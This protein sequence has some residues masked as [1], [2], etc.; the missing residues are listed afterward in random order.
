MATI[1]KRKFHYY[2]PN[3]K[4][5]ETTDGLETNGLQWNVTT[6]IRRGRNVAFFAVLYCSFLGNKLPACPPDI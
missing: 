5:L 3:E 2:R 1:S 6:R 4:Y